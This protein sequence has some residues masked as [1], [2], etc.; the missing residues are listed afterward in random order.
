V[1][2]VVCAR[3]GGGKRDRLYQRRGQ[4]QDVACCLPACR[5]SKGIRICSL[6]LASELVV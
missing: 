4:G 3:G 5:S 6:L 1:L 2:A